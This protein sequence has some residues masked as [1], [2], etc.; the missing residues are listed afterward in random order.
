MDLVGEDTDGHPEVCLDREHIAENIDIIDELCLK[1]YRHAGL[2]DR[3][4]ISPTDIE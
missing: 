3:T 4:R 2:N 1:Y